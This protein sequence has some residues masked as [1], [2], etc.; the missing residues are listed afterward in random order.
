MSV[1][2]DALDLPVLLREQIEAAREVGLYDSD[3]ELIADAIRVLLAARPDV[4]VASA[5]R[6]YEV[7]TVSL[8]KGAELAGLD[9]VGF[10]R[11]LDER[12]IDRRAPESADETAEMAE[13]ALTVAGRAP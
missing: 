12:G 9:I 5:C 8:G 11:E 3:T 4:R 13:T 1:S 7:G 10:K 2:T 6:M